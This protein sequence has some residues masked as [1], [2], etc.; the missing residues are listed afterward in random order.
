MHQIDR[1]RFVGLGLAAA[2]LAAVS[3]ST[4]ALAADARTAFDFS[5]ERIEGGAMPLSQWRGRPLLIVNTASECGYT[6]Q[7]S[8][9]VKLWE[10]YRDKGLVVVGVPSN[11]FG[12]QEPGKEGDIKDFC[13]TTFGVDFPLA[14]KTVV[15]GTGAHPFYLWAAETLGPGR[16][17]KWNFHKYLV[18]RDGRLLGAFSSTTEPMSDA[19]TAAVEQA[20]AA[21]SDA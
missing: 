6:F 10:R 4:G 11:D 3:R 14:T 16:A 17:P 2:T 9:L 13:E 7:Y 18:G 12:G 8:G 19:V 1:R 20:L 21:K 5:F 15:R